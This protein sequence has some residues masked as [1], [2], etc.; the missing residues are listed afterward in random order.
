MQ[1][2]ITHMIYAYHSLGPDNKITLDSLG[3]QA[4]GAASFNLIPNGS[5]EV[6]DVSYITHLRL[7]LLHIVIL[8]KCSK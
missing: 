6:F 4:L 3:P 7:N 1:P 8:F 5:E 2:G